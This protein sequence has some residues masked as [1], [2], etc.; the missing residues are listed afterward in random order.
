MPYK[1]QDSPQG[2]TELEAMAEAE[3][4]RL[5]RQYRIMEN[6]RVAYAEDARLQLCNQ[7]NMI[8]RFECERAELVLAIKKA[9][10]PL[11]LKK[12]EMLETKLKCLL[13]KRAEFIAIIKDEKQQ[14]A[15]VQEQ[16]LKVKLG[17]SIIPDLIKF[18]CFSHS[19]CKLNLLLIQLSD[20]GIGSSL[21]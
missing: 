7:L 9:K 19:I 14:I 18:Y 20:I 17:W 21:N 15:E 8:E 6:D 3:L 2:E 11:N 1:D 16:I 10:S 4:S 5:K 13:E 12:D